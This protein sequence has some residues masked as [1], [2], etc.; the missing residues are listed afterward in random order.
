MRE[1]AHATLD[2]IPQLCELLAL[3]FAQE[4]EFAP[5]HSKQAA[6]LREI[7]TQ[8]KVGRILILREGGAVIAMV[9]LLF[10]VSTA[11]GG[12]VAMLEDM[13]VHPAHRGSGAGSRLLQGAV[14]YV[15][16][17][18]C[19]RIT[20]LTDRDN[21]AAQG[22]YQHHGFEPSAMLPMRLSLCD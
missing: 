13:I 11:L 16:Y 8:P 20:L 5:D 12:R 19:L 2:D 17:E 7:I 10:T 1:L 18:G 4:A 15:R 9:N 22:F 14:E 6:G 21:D 3:L